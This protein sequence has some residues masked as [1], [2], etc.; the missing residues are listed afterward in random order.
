MFAVCD[1]S[2][3]LVCVSSCV[4][5]LFLSNFPAENSG[6]GVPSKTYTSGDKVV[7]SS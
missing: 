1:L 6:G 7:D 5:F 4:C 2:F 3:V